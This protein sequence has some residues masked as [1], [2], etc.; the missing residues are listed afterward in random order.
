MT[1]KPIRVCCTQCEEALRCKS[2]VHARIVSFGKI[3]GFCVSDKVH[4]SSTKILPVYEGICRVCMDAMADENKKVIATKKKKRED[5]K[6]S[7]AKAKAGKTQ[8]S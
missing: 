6:K 7:R 1:I 5:K 4:A 8:T 2:T 3:T